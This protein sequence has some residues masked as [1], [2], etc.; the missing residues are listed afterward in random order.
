M[1]MALAWT[2][3]LLG[4]EVGLVPDAPPIPDVLLAP[5]DSVSHTAL[6]DALEGSPEAEAAVWRA[7]R[8]DPH[9]ARAH[10]VVH[11]GRFAGVVWLDEGVDG[12]ARVLLKDGSSASSEVVHRAT[13][14]QRQMRQA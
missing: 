10:L 4:L 2:S 6:S 13:L 8:D 5:S 1:G 3:E 11:H 7:A 14:L 12:S 9:G